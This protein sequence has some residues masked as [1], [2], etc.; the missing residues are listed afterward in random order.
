M[1]DKLRVYRCKKRTLRV[2]NSGRQ[3]EGT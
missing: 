2:E 3:R 1:Q